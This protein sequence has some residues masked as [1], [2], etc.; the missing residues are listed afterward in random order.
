ML[1]YLQLS[2]PVPAIQSYDYYLLPQVLPHAII[3]LAIICIFAVSI[4]Q[5][6]HEQCQCCVAT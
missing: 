4:L 5:V 2:H 6:V 3:A 1:C